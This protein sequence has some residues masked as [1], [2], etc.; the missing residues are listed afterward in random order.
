MCGEPAQFSTAAPR[1][2]KRSTS[3]L[4]LSTYSIAFD[5]ACETTPDEL[6]ADVIHAME[7][8]K[9]AGNWLGFRLQPRKWKN[10]NDLAYFSFDL[11]F[12]PWC[13]RCAVRNYI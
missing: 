7:T 6:F 13:V 4:N 3:T 5:A 12:K 1:T 2:A 10:L 8:E 9:N 11:V